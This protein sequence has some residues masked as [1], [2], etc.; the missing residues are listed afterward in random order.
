MNSPVVTINHKSRGTGK[1]DDVNEFVDDND[2]D[3]DNQN[4]DMEKNEDVESTLEAIPMSVDDMLLLQAATTGI[5]KK[6]GF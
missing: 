5:R 6:C 4:N 3:N 2:N 1:Q